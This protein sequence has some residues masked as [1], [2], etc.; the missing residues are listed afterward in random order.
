MAKYSVSVMFSGEYE[1]DSE[2]EAEQ[3]ALSEMESGGYIG[4]ELIEEEEAE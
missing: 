1:A 2:F 3:L 4:A